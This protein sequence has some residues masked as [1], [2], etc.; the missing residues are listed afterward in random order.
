MNKVVC[1]EAYFQTWE[2]KGWLGSTTKKSSDCRIDAKRL[3]KDV[4]S[5]VEELNREGFEVVAITPLTSG[6]YEAS[7]G[8]DGWGYGFSFT[9]AVL[10]TAICKQQLATT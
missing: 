2:E 9:E 5:A 3:Q 4:Q 1:V 8:Y 7:G 6:M 10:I